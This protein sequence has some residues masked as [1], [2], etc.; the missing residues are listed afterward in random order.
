MAKETIKKEVILN[1][2]TLSITNFEDGDILLLSEIQD[3]I[4]LLKSKYKS[5]K[6]IFQ[7]LEKV[8]YEISRMLNGEDVF[9]FVDFIS[10]AI[11]FIISGSNED[12]KKLLDKDFSN[13]GNSKNVLSENYDLSNE[14]IKIFIIEAEERLVQAQEIIM[15]L[16]SDLDNRK[17][18]DDLFRVFHTIKGEC[19][20][21]NLIKLGELTHNLE[22][23]L[24]MMKYSEIDNNADIIDIILTGVDI[25]NELLEALK[26]KNY[27]SYNNISICETILKIES[28]TTK[29][30]VPLGEVLEKEGLL[31]KTQVKNIKEEQKKSGFKKKFG[32]I[33]TDKKI[34]EQSHIDETLKKQRQLQI[35][36][37]EFIKVSA[38]QV[39]Y[40]VDMIGELII[41]ENQINADG[42][43]FLHKITKEIQQTAMML[44][45]VKI[46]NLLI[47]MKRV[48]RDAS[49][50]LNKNVLLELE[51]E[52]LEV[53]R[54]LVEHLEEPLIHLLRN[55]VGHGIETP[56][57]RSN[58]NKNDTGKILIRAERVGNQIKIFVRDDGCGLDSELILNKALNKGL[59]SAEKAKNIKE[60]EVFNLIFL[61]GFSTSETVNNVS[62]R[63]VGMD[64]VKKTVNSLRGNISITSQKDKFTEFTLT[65][66]L[67]MAIIDS[68]IILVDDINFIL[69][70]VNIIE[71]LKFN[72]DEI[73]YLESKDPVISLRNEI[74]PII[75]LRSFFKM[76]NTSKP[77]TEL[78]VIVEYQK[79]KYAFIV[80]QIVTQK[81]VVI[82]SLGDKLPKVSGISAA[83]ILSGGIIGYIINVDEV[84]NG[85]PVISM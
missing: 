83:T 51:G 11:D 65:F 8:E 50:K 84:I 74:I 60:E 23:L 80:D 79:R 76:N 38:S 35:K 3:D 63:G 41:A 25:S 29:G 6:Y 85:E 34:L 54:N 26:D 32:E 7:L 46:K 45:T 55:S 42:I 58:K 21:L 49:K 61:P 57:E 12:I 48:V 14:T 56:E 16:E 15:E 20:F 37:D 53:D 5:R 81:E 10:D 66:P 77:E 73:H 59:I 18:I 4:I 70:V 17:K 33:I 72:K 64:I 27:K 75:E 1:R 69:P 24:D 36:E 43:E 31:S 2:L 82:K 47:N 78:A 28:Y 9:Y 52:D 13:D 62:G 68:M 19:G 22:N 30:R 71:T 44:R 40:L 67:I 39:N